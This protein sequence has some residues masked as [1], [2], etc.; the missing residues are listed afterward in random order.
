[1]R[2]NTLGASK[3]RGGADEGG[4]PRRKVKNWLIEVSI[5][6]KGR[7]AGDK[8]LLN[9]ARGCLEGGGRRAEITLSVERMKGSSLG[10][11][12]NGGRDFSNKTRRYGRSRKQRGTIKSI[13]R[14]RERRG[15]WP[16]DL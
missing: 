3:G 13:G 8:V 9:C 15:P 2:R 1:M 16:T 6:F 10:N 12:E 5:S 4:G 11:P 7:I 14:N